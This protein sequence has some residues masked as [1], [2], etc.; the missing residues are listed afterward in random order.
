MFPVVLKGP[1]GGAQVHI[2]G[3]IRVMGKIWYT[4]DPLILPVTLIDPV[5]FRD[6]EFV[7]DEFWGSAN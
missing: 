3:R 7:A 1:L 5:N 6:T 4:I 2:T